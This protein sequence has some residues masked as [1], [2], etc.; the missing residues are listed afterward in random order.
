M[1]ILWLI[2]FTLL[3]SPA[4]AHPRLFFPKE[5]EASV[6]QRI[7]QDPLA[8]RMQAYILKEATRSLKERTCEYRIPD[9]KRL[10]FES[11]HALYHVLFTAWAWRTTGDERFLQ[12]GI[13]EL[14]AASGLKDWNPS[15]FLDTAEMATAVAIGYDW[16]YPV[17]DDAQKMRYEDALLDKG[18]R[19][20]HGYNKPPGWWAAPS[21]NW[22]QVTGAGM[23]LA[24]MAVQDRDPALCA[25]VLQQSRELVSACGKFYQPDGAYPEG[26]A[27]WHYGTNYHILLT[28]AAET[29][30]SPMPAGEELRKAGRFMQHLTGPTRLPFNFAD[31]NATLQVPS[32]SQSWIASHFSDDSQ[33]L[34]VR[35]LMAAALDA[36]IARNT[37]SDVRFFPLH[38]LWLPPA[39]P[40]TTAAGERAAV[41]QGE[42]SLASFRTAW[43][44]DA[45][46]LAIKGGTGAASHGHL[47]GGVFVYEAGGVRWFH[48]MGMEDYNLPGYFGKKRWSYFRLTNSAHNTLVI[49]GQLQAT[50]DTGA[51]I[52]GFSTD[53]K[54]SRATVDLNPLYPGQASRVERLVEFDQVSGAVRLTDSLKAPSGPVR[55]AVITQAEPS[56]HGKTV[57]LKEDGRS[58][59]ITRHDSHGGAWQ[60]FS[61]KPPTPEE[62]QNEGFHLIGFEAPAAAQMKLEVSWK[63]VKTSP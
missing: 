4:G 52:H 41:F 51:S 47:D 23:A 37:S 7:A 2:L 5:S 57:T 59:E 49:G 31:G 24:A 19:V 13:Q 60:E 32:P 40:A 53:N 22:S 36:G 26:A 18:L 29:A 11:R 12:R 55:W 34:H 63:P 50:P 30:R 45:A 3:C 16:F 10:L 15:H 20:I 56:F 48:D 43:T 14:E 38:L 6:R 28:A 27:Y 62:N 44:P 58:L 8:A 35:S 54:N 9:G 46:W 61:L 33:A 39:P 25:A 1:R 21:N 42:Q 17:L